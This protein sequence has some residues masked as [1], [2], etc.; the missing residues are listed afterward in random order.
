MSE[1]T[2]AAGSFEGG[3]LLFIIL[4]IMVL[5]NHSWPSTPG[6]YRY[7]AARNNRSG[8][9]HKASRCCRAAN[10]A[11]LDPPIGA[12]QAPRQDSARDV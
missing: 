7:T 8:S 6:Q 2:S 9:G 12:L 3:V 4:V 10:P 5:V 11:D 1:L